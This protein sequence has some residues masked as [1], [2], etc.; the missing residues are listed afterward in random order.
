MALYEPPGDED[1]CRGA[2]SPASATNSSSDHLSRLLEGPLE[3]AEA[4][5]EAAR[6]RPTADSEEDE[7]SNDAARRRFR[8]LSE[9]HIAIL[10]SLNQNQLLKDFVTCFSEERLQGKLLFCLLQWLTKS[11]NGNIPSMPSSTT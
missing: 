9:E 4:A 5:A 2:S 10:S 11:V 3:A 8:N 1:G 6:L 7:V